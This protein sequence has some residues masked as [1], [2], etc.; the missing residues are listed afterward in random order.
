MSKKRS[1]P[2]H[3]EGPSRFEG[4]DQHGWAPDVDET[5]QQP[6]PSAHRSF[7]PDK[8][9]PEPDAGR[10]ATDE[11]KKKST[12]GT[13]MGSTSRRGEEQAG[14][15]KG[16]GMHDTGR[17]GRTQR[18]S[19]SKDA[20]AFSGVDPQDPSSKKSGKRSGH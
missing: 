8:H 6:N 7:D 5:S 20:S 14:K 17:K 9:A 4:R 3:G 13:P 1:Q 16:E 11:D 2:S 18:P 15:S 19:G 10:A 12:A